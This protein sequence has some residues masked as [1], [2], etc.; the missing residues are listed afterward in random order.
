LVR[1]PRWTPEAGEE[2]D[3]NIEWDAYKRKQ[4]ED[5]GMVKVRSPTRKKPSKKRTKTSKQKNKRSLFA[6]L[7]S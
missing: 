5:D 6:R 7:L 3:A 2:D 4:R 1:L